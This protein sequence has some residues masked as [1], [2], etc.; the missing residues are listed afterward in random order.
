MYILQVLN[1]GAGGYGEIEQKFK[2]EK[3]LIDMDNRVV[4]AG[5]EQGRQRWKRVWRVN[6]KGKIQ[7]N[8]KYIKND[9]NKLKYFS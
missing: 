5:W 8:K 9:K 7:Q 6:V 2:N 4:A 3:E 1:L